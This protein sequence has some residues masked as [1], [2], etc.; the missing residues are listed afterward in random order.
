MFGVGAMFE[1][2]SGKAV[3][4]RVRRNVLQIGD[5]GVLVDDGPEKLP[6]QWLFLVYKDMKIV[7]AWK[8]LSG[9]VVRQ[10]VDCALSDRDCSFFPPFTKTGNQSVVKIKVSLS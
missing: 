10:G 3:S 8:P 6:C 5:R 2:M 4:Q 9:D 7:C 1:Q